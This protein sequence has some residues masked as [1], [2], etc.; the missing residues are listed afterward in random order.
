M[1]FLSSARAIAQSM[2]PHT[3]STVP[4]ICHLRHPSFAALRAPVFR[5]FSNDGV[6][7]LITSLGERGA[8]LT[9]PAVQRL[10]GIVDDSA[11]GRM[12]ASIAQATLCRPW[13]AAARPAGR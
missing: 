7:V 6:P 1:R 8:A 3:H 4:D 10:L 13:S 5:R 12:L 11:D 2:S 9:L